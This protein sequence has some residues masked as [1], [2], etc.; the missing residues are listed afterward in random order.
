MRVG[1]VEEGVDGDNFEF[2]TQARHDFVDLVHRRP[3]T[4][5]NRQKVRA[6]GVQLCQIL[7][8]T[9][10]VVHS[11]FGIQIVVKRYQTPGLLAILHG[12]NEEKGFSYKSGIL[13]IAFGG[14][15]QVHAK[16]NASL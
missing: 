16:Q 15:N 3:L 7:H 11:A 10:C 12:T 4:H 8:V 1:E 5:M 2:K 6:S 13:H 14:R 9:Y